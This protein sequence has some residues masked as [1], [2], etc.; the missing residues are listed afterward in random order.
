MGPIARSHFYCKSLTLRTGGIKI[1]YKKLYEIE[2]SKNAQLEQHYK[3]AVSKKALAERK[4]VDIVNQYESIIFELEQIKYE[5]KHTLDLVKTR[6]A[7]CEELYRALL[8]IINEIKKSR[9]KRFGID[10]NL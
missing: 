8:V 10:I 1:N 4:S 9:P 7:E 5:Y 3:T 2:L 6:A